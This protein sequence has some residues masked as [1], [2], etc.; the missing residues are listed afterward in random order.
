MGLLPA[1]RPLSTAGNASPAAHL[2]LGE[3][4]ISVAGF[5]LPSFT[6]LSSSLSLALPGTRAR[7][8][9]RVIWTRLITREPSLEARETTGWAVASRSTPAPGGGAAAGP[10][11]HPGP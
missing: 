8:R 9:V 2:A 5:S 1:G 4:R 10:A 3:S 6:A 11:P 7:A